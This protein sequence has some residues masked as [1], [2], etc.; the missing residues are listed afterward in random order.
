[1]MFHVKPQRIQTN[2]YSV[3]RL[4]ALCASCGVP[5]SGD[6]SALLLRHLDLVLSHNESVNLTAVTERAEALRLH[7]VD[8]LCVVPAISE[9][10]RP[11]GKLLDL[12]TGA[13]F[14]G[15]PVSV[16]AAVDCVLMDSTRKKTDFLSSAVRELGLSDSVS[17]VNARAEDAARSGEYL[18]SGVLARAVASLPTLV[19]LSSPLLQRDGLL[20]CMK[21]QVEQL[22]LSSGDRAAA[23]CAMSR[24]ARLD[25]ALPGGPERRSVIVYRKVGDTPVNLPRRTGM[26]KKRPLG[27]R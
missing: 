25:Y 22:E 10:E 1:M 19:E 8:S 5:L 27:T 13:G 12:G 26:A 7:V 18:M 6:D 15:I 3:E 9:F 16:A 14:P 20:Y 24:E 11:D 21:A 4:Q 23:L 17:V 2:S